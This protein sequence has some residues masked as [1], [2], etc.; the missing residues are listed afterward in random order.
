MSYSA[1]SGR[2]SDAAGVVV[3]AISLCEVG[4]GGEAAIGV[5]MLLLQVGLDGKDAADDVLDGVAGVVVLAGAVLLHMLRSLLDTSKLG[6][7][8]HSG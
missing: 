8:R 3:A 1:L 5:M 7:E 4:L 6:E 2:S